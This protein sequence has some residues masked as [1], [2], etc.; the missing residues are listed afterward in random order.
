MILC[1]W[2]MSLSKEDA[3]KIANYLFTHKWLAVGYSTLME[4]LLVTDIMEAVNPKN[5]KDNDE[6]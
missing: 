3:L 2:K 5:G 6:S 1:R 4:D